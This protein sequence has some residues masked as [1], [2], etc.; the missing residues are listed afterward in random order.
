MN[1][2]TETP[3]NAE[4]ALTVLGEQ[5]FTALLTG[6]P[7]AELGLTPDEIDRLNRG[8]HHAR[9]ITHEEVDDYLSMWRITCECGNVYTDI[10]LS[11]AHREHDDHAHVAHVNV[12]PVMRAEMLES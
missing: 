9:A 5:R 2:T 1:R 7:P 6:T 8:P 10:R 11:V 12:R 3:L 4:H